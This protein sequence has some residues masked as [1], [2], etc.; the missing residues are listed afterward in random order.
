MARKRIVLALPVALGLGV[1]LW[2][3]GMA[4]EEGPKKPPA[5]GRPA[6]VAP[7]RVVEASPVEP[8]AT[9]RPVP[10]P[11]ASGTVEPSAIQSRVGELE[12]RLRDL[13]ARRDALTDAN[14]DLEKRAA[15]RG[16]EA[17]ALA[18]ADWRVRAWEKQ[19]GLTES[20]RQEV[21]DLAKAWAKGDAGGKA[22]RETWAL[23][24]GELRSRLT[25]EQAARLNQSTAEQS[26]RMWSQMGQAVGMYAGMSSEEQARLQPSLGSF[27]LPNSALLPEAHGADWPGMIREAAGR[28]RP[29]LTAAQAERVDKFIARF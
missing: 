11:A 5:K 27:P 22:S 17:G 25:T 26:A 16:A 21:L 12:A 8:V 20:Q 6:P 15:E 10:A 1:L 4:R 18:Q 13:E 29:M 19:L 7:Q 24:E 9:A 23:R 2:A 14:R 28:A 3:L